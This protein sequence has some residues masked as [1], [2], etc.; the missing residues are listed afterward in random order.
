MHWWNSTLAEMSGGKWWRAALILTV[1]HIAPAMVLVGLWVVGFLS[2]FDSA[3]W[4][5]STLAV[6][7]ALASLIGLFARFGF[8]GT[9][10]TFGQS[11]GEDLEATFPRWI[12]F[13]LGWL[14][15]LL[16]IVAAMALFAS[17]L[18]IVGNARWWH[19]AGTPELDSLRARAAKMP[20]PSDWHLVATDASGTGFPRFMEWSAGPEPEG[21]VEKT[22]NVPES[23]GF[24]DLKAWI[25]GSQWANRSGGA[26]FGAIQRNRCDIGSSSCRAHL[27]PPAGKEPEFFIRARFDES[28]YRGEENEV[29]VRLT[30][31]QHA[32][33]TF[34]VSDSTV[35]RAQRL[36]VPAGWTRYD[37]L[38]SRTINGESITQF[39]EV[40]D[41]FDRVDL[42]AWLSGPAW[43]QGA[44]PFGALVL[45]DEPC[46]EVDSGS[47]FPRWL[48]SAIVEGTQ[49]DPLSGSKWNGPVESIW[50][51][52][53]PDHSVLLNLSR[54][55]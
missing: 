17:T 47:E 15:W 36:P 37:L 42:E 44:D 30:Y 22:F 4:V 8:W 55:G 28:S 46:R 53:D 35:A 20:I 40:P 7:F 21:F 45:D 49:R 29:R 34:S 23:F 12:G 25:S 54:N 50:V 2:I 9:P 27:I 14:R 18:L 16:Q 52:L 19:F 1:A 51:S 31:K 11:G 41:D 32:P 3:R 13:G 33:P 38:E 26:S 6:V 48:C 43:T 39:F 24:S 5:L 10:S